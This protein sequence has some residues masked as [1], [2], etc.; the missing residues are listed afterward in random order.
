MFDAGSGLTFQRLETGA[1]RVLKTKSERDGEVLV[2]QV[3]T[4]VQFTE[5]VLAMT[6]PAMSGPAPTTQPAAAAADANAK[7]MA[8]LAKA[9]EAARKAARGGGAQPPKPAA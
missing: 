2:D 4:P 1:V 7:R 8:N 3:L 6:P 9:R 5:L